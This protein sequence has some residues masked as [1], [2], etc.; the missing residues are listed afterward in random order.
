M[1]STIH[2][3]TF[4]RID[5]R[6]ICSLCFVCYVE[7]KISLVFMRGI[8]HMESIIPILM[9]IVCANY[10]GKLATVS[11]CCL[12]WDR[13]YAEGL[14]NHSRCEVFTTVLFQMRY[15]FCDWHCY[16]RSSSRRFNG[17][18]HS[19]LLTGV[20]R[21]FETWWIARSTTQRYCPK[22]SWEIV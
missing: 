10:S 6:P 3:V 16:W 9:L 13:L 8:G 20:L 19:S 17:S 4:P 11:L 5:D 18:L 15:G 14:R 12:S 21:S 1:R 22:D 7:N 2:F